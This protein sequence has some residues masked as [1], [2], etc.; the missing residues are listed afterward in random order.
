M[1]LSRMSLADHSAYTRLA[2]PHKHKDILSDEPALKVIDKLNVSQA[3]P[4]GAN[5][6]LTLDNVDP[7]FS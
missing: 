7:T 6:I 3:L 5:L 4:A 2:I 1:V